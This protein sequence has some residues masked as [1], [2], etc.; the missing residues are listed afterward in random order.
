MLNS[1]LKGLFD[2]AKRQPGEIKLH[3]IFF[4]LIL[5]NFSAASARFLFVLV[6]SKSAKNEL[7]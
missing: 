6:S 7:Q 4:R 2:D 5:L 3:L 1:A